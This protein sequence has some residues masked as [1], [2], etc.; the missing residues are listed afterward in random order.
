MAILKTFFPA[1][2]RKRYYH[3]HSSIPTNPQTHILT[4]GRHVVVVG[5]A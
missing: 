4:G 3:T 2:R 5:S 1:K